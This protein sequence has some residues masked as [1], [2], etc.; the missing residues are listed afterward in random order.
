MIHRIPLYERKRWI[1]WE[2]SGT[3]YV[4]RLLGAERY[5]IRLR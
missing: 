3:L 2:R 4:L 5:H 1:R